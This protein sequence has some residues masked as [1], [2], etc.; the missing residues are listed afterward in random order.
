MEELNKF[1]SYR[2][3]KIQTKKKLALQATF[4]ALYSKG[5]DMAEIN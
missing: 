4:M 2:N 5:Y 1:S 3:L